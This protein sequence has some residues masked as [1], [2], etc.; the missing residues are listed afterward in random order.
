MSTPLG[1]ASSE[2]SSTTDSVSVKGS[3]PSTLAQTLLAFVMLGIFCGLW[4]SPPESFYV[5]PERP[6]IALAA[7]EP[8]VAAWDQGDFQVIDASTGKRI[9]QQRIPYRHRVKAASGTRSWQRW[10][11][12]DDYV[13]RS[14]SDSRWGE[15]SRWPKIDFWSD[16]KSVSLVHENGESTI[17]HLPSGSLQSWVNEKGDPRSD[18]ELVQVDDLVVA[19]QVTRNRHPLTLE[20]MQRGDGPY[21]VLWACNPTTLSRE[22]SDEQKE[23]AIGLSKSP[24]DEDRNTARF[25][26]SV[27]YVKFEND[28]NGLEVEA[29][30]FEMSDLWLLGDGKAIGGFDPYYRDYSWDRSPFWHLDK[31]KRLATRLP[32]PFKRGE[33]LEPG[34]IDE[35]LPIVLGTLNSPIKNRLGVS[36]R[37]VAWN[38]V[39]GAVTEIPSHVTDVKSFGA[40]LLMRFENKAAWL[41]LATGKQTTIVQLSK[42]LRFRKLFIVLAWIGAWCFWVRPRAQ[43][44]FTRRF[45][46]MLMLL[47]SAAIG[48]GHLHVV[49]IHLQWMTMRWFACLSFLI[50]L[51]G[52][53]AASTMAKNVSRVMLGVGWSM[54]LCL[55][56][57]FASASGASI[58]DHKLFVPGK[59]QWPP[60][61]TL[62]NALWIHLSDANAMPLNPDDPASATGGWGGEPC[63]YQIEF[64]KQIHAVE[65]DEEISDEPRRAKDASRA[66]PD[67]GDPF[68]E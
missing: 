65:A 45:G 19:V 10:P 5:Q 53:L 36:T 22:I 35:R 38:L 4:M 46:V 33:T 6:I 29:E 8:L 27:E 59:N 54:L 51:L 18:I 32:W 56:L 39:T 52:L 57:G 60:P 11:G 26:Y 7:R 43:D 47:V 28:I 55:L 15:P 25:E 63:E 34:A 37:H 17:V 67:R 66:E 13:E 64:L 12:I 49:G 2:S 3:P 62:R 61:T 50:P 21:E 31:E 16:D 1:K 40:S 68:G 30:T 58:M 14:F 20:S 48:I 23:R 24:P 44:D 41:D 42:D 9:F